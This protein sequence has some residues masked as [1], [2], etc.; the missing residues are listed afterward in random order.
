MPVKDAAGDEGHSAQSPGDTGKSGPLT[1][2]RIVEMAAIGPVP[3]AAMLL[4][5]M[6][7][8]IVRVDR[9][10]PVEGHAVINRGRK[11]VVLDLKTDHGRAEALSLIAAADVLLEGFR[12]GV[13]ERLGLG[14][15]Q[16][17]QQNPALV[18][19]RMT[20]WGQDGPLA[21][22]AGHDIN[23][24][25]VSGA[26]AAMGAPD[27]PPALPLNLVGD[28]GGGAL[29]LAL[30]VLA[31]VMSARS[32]G[33]GQVVDASITEGA[34]SLM[35]VFYHF[36]QVGEW[37][38][39]RGTNSVDGGA[40]FYGTFECADGRFV[41]VAPMEPQFW[42]LFKEKLGLGEAF[43]R[44]DERSAWPAMVSELRALFLTR[45]SAHWCG[46]LEGTDVCFAPVLSM[47]EAMDYPLFVERG[48]FV[49]FAGGM[50]PG[51]APRFS[52]TATHVSAPERDTTTA[53]VC[54]RW[55]KT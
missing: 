53:A 23:Y 16:V 4:A 30:G 15:D 28:Y 41:S 49:P 34:L 31:A 37:K 38:P 35:S 7:A 18:Y 51:V 1:G 29:Y 27:R 52:V 3:F 17:L 55:Q 25:A 46:L 32:T 45:P 14:P 47:T 13:M 44:R 9:P 24:I 36:Q 10:Q 21:H 48:S 33:C 22:A 50:V 26:L 39:E 12:P 8:E 5:D 11:R 43:D 6:G 2:L 40:P 42:R 54:E 19:G 20:G